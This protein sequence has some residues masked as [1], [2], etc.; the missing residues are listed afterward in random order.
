MLLS[1]A[2][3]RKSQAED[4]LN[5]QQNLANTQHNF[6]NTLPDKTIALFCTFF[7]NVFGKYAH[8]QF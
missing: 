6:A 8:F 7:E 1:Y 2:E 5:A 4:I 3:I